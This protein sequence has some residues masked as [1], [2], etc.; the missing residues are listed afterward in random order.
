MLS[1][2]LDAHLPAMVERMVKDEI[3][4]IAGKRA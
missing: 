3:A 4:R 1:E 2:W